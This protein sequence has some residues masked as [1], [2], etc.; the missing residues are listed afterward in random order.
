MTISKNRIHELIDRLSDKDLELVT[1]LMERLS[2]TTTSREIPLDDEP[3]TQ[4][5][6]DAINSATEA[7]LKGELINFKDV[8]HELRS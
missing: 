6:L 4:E 2:Q 1:D 7:Y 8:E 3:T 5:D